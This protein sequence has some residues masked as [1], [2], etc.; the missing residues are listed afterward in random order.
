MIPDFAVWLGSGALVA[1]LAG[2]AAWRL[3]R[4]RVD[5]DVARLRDDI[6]ALLAEPGAGSRL[7]VNGRGGEFVDIAAS[8]NRLLDRAEEAV[9]APD[10]EGLF[11][12]LADTLPG[13]ALIHSESIHFANRAAGELF[14]MEPQMLVD[15]PVTDLLRQI[16]RAS[17]RERV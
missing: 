14:G 7:V 8:V 1:A 6:H 13:I 2:L 17:C 3:G 12:N 4:R 15:K 9:P 16:G 10:T 5:A 11:R